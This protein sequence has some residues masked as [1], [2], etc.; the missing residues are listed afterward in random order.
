[1][2]NLTKLYIAMAIL[3]VIIGI[4]KWLTVLTLGTALIG[5]IIGYDLDDE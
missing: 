5:E 3:F 1:M 2:D 4:P